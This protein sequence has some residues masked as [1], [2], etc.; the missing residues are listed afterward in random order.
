M[1]ELKR[2]FSAAKMNKDLDE[3]LIPNGQY[4][5]A[6]NIQITT[7]DGSNVGSAQTLLGNTRK[8]DMPDFKSGIDG[9]Y[10][11]ILSDAKSTCIGSIALPDKDK[12]YYLIAAGLNNTTRAKLDIQKDYIIEYDTIKE[13]LLYVFVDIYQVNEETSASSTS[14]EAFLYIPNLSSATINKTGVRIGMQVSG[15]L[16]STTYV[17]EDGITVKD[18]IYNSGNTSYKI[19]LQKDGSDFTPA[20]GVGSGDA[21]VFSSPRVLNF[22]YDR[23][24][25]AIN[26][27]DDLLFWTDNVTEPKK[28]NIKRSISGTGGEEYL[29]GG[30]VGSPTNAVFEGETDYF[31]TRLVIDK[32]NDGRLKVVTDAAVQKAVYVEEKHV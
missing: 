31:H 8:F 5:D 29:I 19:F 11:S 25:T 2:N 7:S 14:S 9:V 32:N 4:K 12:I 16:G 26:V 30:G 21:I 24:V 15:T 20:T 18:I 10:S 6:L 17:K 23:K 13:T 3:R 1:P 28:I 27:I 22:D